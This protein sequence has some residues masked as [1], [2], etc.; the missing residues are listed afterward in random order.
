MRNNGFWFYIK[1]YFYIN[2]T[3]G[4]PDY[5]FVFILAKLTNVLGLIKF[6]DDCEYLET[7][8]MQPS[9]T[10]N[11]E[12]RDFSIAVVYLKCV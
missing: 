9:N 4:W 8:A 7:C 6:D 10:I 2:E 5:S 3:L 11:N 12:Q 1:A